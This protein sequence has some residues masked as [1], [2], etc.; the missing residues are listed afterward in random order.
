MKQFDDRGLKQAGIRLDRHRRR[1]RRRFVGEHGRTRFGVVT[2][3]AHYSP[4]TTRLENK[5]YVDAFMKANNGMRPNFHY[6][7]A[8]TACIFIYAAVK[9]TGGVANDL[10]LSKMKG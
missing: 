10:A 4:R 9:K 3:P 1:D 7:A 8:T 5:A 2:P 6:S